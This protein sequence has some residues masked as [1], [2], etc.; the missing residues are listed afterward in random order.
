M[1]STLLERVFKLLNHDTNKTPAQ[2]FLD[3]HSRKLDDRELYT[4]RVLNEA[5]Q[6]ATYKEVVRRKAEAVLRTLR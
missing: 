3:S 2:I 5:L 4:I 1:R 6:R